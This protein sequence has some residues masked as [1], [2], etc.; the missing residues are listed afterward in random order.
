LVG[1]LVE[2]INHGMTTTTR[3]KIQTI[4]ITKQ[5]LPSFSLLGGGGHAFHLILVMRNNQNGNVVFCVV[6]KAGKQH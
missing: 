1:W 3:W 6:Y 5:R 2:K 4:G